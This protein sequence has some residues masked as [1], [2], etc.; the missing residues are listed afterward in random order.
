MME[1]QVPIRAIYEENDLEEFKRSNS[2]KE[3][4]SFVKACSESVTGVS[5]ESIPID[6]ISESIQKCK[7]F[8]GLLSSLIDEIP[9]L[10]QPMRYG[11]KAFRDWHAR[12]LLETDKFLTDLL[13]SE[14]QSAKIELAPYINQSFGNETRIDYGTGHEL[15]IILFYLCLCK[16]KVLTEKDF[17]SIISIGFWSYIQLMRKLQDVYMLEPAGSH[18]V[19]GLDDYH[20]LSFVFGSAQLI[21]H[22]TIVPNSINDNDILKEYSSSYLYLEGISFIKKIKSK[23]PFHETSPMLHDI[24]GLSDW[25]KVHT[26][27]LRLFQGEVLGKLPVIQH[28]LFGSLLSKSWTPNVQHSPTM[29]GVGGMHSLLTEDHIKSLQSRTHTYLH[30]PAAGA[31]GTHVGPT[32]FTPPSVAPGAMAPPA[33]SAAPAS[34]VYSHAEFDPSVM[35]RAPWATRPN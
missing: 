4:I 1:Y 34:T 18:G 2:Y 29:A 20:C 26:G 21:N 12:L 10:Q 14:L 19:W 13:P 15:N 23:A 3:I 24:S 11:N 17:Q 9:P 6:S 28:V 30:S 5:F 22:E 31:A 8:M 7:A 25:T 27:L 16:L 33:V 35:T 32:V